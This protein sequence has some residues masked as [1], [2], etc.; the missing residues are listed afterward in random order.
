MATSQRLATK[1][2]LFFK[3]FNDFILLADISNLLLNRGSSI[4]ILLEYKVE[5]LKNKK[6]GGHAAEDQNPTQTSSW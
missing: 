3:W 4:F 1:E 6:V 2:G 5:K